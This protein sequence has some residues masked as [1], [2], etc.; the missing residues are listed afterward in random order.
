MSKRIKIA[1]IGAGN[2]GQAAHLRNYASPSMVEEC[3]VVALAEIRPELARRVAARYEI[4]RV[5]GSHEEL[6][7]NEKLDALVASQPF[8]RHGMILPELAKAGLP[9]FVEKPIAGSIEMGEKVVHAL[10][11]NK[12]WLMMGYHKRSDLATAY[13]R[14]EITKLKASGELGALR[15]IRLEMPPGDWLAGGFN[16]LLRSDEKT[17]DLEW[18]P[19]P[20]GLSAEDADTYIT[21]VNYYIHQINLLRYLLGESYRVTY[22]DPS[23]VL[24]VAHSVSGVC[25]TIEMAAY[26][27]TRDWNE[28][29]FIAFE[30]GF[31]KLRLPAPG[32][33]NRAGEVEIFKDTG[34]T[35]M[36]LKP[37]LPWEHAMR[38]QALNFIRAV[39]GEAPA[40][41]LAPEALEDL[42]IAM[43]W[44]KLWKGI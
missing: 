32:A 9:I 14:E 29:A 5:Y 20:A 31:V 34:G 23:K 12:T 6:L 35:P 44:L 16:D 25:C 38:S 19:A 21:F 24:F 10:E 26:N 41:C 17:P 11:E 7:A 2:M 18:D 27:T 4:P 30:K 13:A 37:T 1:F 8:I 33:F 3:E 28:T 36:T 42:R 40:P 15:Y 22:A 43:D 39:R